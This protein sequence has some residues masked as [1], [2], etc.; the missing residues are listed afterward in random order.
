VKRPLMDDEDFMYV[1]RRLRPCD[2]EFWLW[3]KLTSLET[4]VTFAVNPNWP[5]IVIS[6]EPRTDVIPGSGEVS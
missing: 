4:E 3:T 2:R 5:G 1:V 6:D